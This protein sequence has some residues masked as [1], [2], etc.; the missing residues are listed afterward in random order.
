MYT[1]VDMFYQMSLLLISPDVWLTRL[2]TPYGH[3]I[4]NFKAIIKPATVAE[5]CG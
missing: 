1:Y 3:P 2:G 5:I 4:T